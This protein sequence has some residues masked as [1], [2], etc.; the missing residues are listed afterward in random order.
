MQSQSIIFVWENF[1]PTQD[2]R[3][4]AV[5]NGL[6]SHKIIGIEYFS[7]SSTYEW[8]PLSNI[9]FKKITL[10]GTS[11]RRNV[12]KI[13]MIIKLISVILKENSK[14]IFLC[15]YDDFAIEVT[16]ILLRFLGRRVY[17][18]IDS[19]FDDYPRFILRE[20]LKA[21]W[22]LPYQGAITGS[23]R[24]QQYLTFLGKKSDIIHLGYDTISVAR[25]RN[26]GKSLPAP[27]GASF[28]ERHFTIIARLV[29]KKNLFTALDGFALYAKTVADPR[30]LR[31]FGSGPLEEDLRRH[32]SDLDIQNLVIFEGFQQTEEICRGLAT[33]LVLLHVSSEEQFGFAIIEAMA[34]GVAVIVSENCGARDYFV[35]T[36]VNG[37]LVES[38]NPEGMAFFMRQLASDEN[39]WRQFC[40]S[41]QASAGKIDTQNFVQS[42]AALTEAGWMPANL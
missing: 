29:P 11:K 38:D 42:V 8:K 20:A 22:L 2:D 27:D 10:F 30:T 37:F 9:N 36:G 19:K 32:A 4:N 34:M 23:T 12:N 15:H 35:R 7:E 21:I 41:A 39:L 14:Y 6:K 28:A 17:L 3:C 16:A 25:I 24:S 31:I 13:N 33:T 18:L 5:A 40:L 26:L 1:G